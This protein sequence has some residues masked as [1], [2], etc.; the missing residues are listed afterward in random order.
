VKLDGVAG[1]RYL[2]HDPCHTPIKTYQPLKVVNQLMGGGVRLNER[3][4][5]EA[6]TLALTRP[7]I[8]TQVRF[9]KEEEMRKGV[10]ALRAE[11]PPRRSREKSRSSP[12]ARP[13]CRVWRAS[14]TMPQR[15]RLHRRGTRPAHARPRLDGRL[16]GQSQSRRHR[17]RIALG[18][19]DA[20]NPT[21]HVEMEYE[22]FA[23]T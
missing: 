5:G 2:Y 17:A 7:D 16:R 22:V 10:A 20:R 14:T 21:R 4:C 3:C 15:R 18:I 9:R 19:A 6:G 11:G 23:A 12:P 8:A 1:V 13:A